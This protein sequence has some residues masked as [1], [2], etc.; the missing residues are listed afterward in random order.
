MAEGSTLGSFSALPPLLSINTL[1]NLSLLLVFTVLL[2]KVFVPVVRPWEAMT[3]RTQALASVRSISSNLLFLE[4]KGIT[5][6]GSGLIH[7]SIVE[8][9]FVNHLFGKSF[10]LLGLLFLV[11]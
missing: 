1:T 2:L 3:Y 10:L 11:F 7:S 9:P 4:V 6:F 5:G 8:L